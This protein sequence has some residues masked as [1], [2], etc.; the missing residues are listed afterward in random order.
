MHINL[1]MGHTRLV[2]KLPDSTDVC[3]PNYTADYFVIIRTLS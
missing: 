1:G 3:W 2:Y